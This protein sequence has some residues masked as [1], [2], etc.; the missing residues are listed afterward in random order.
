M[1][2][3][4]GKVGVVFKVQDKIVVKFLQA[5]QYKPEFAVSFSQVSNSFIANSSSE[6][7][8]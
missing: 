3:K 7:R 4:D 1:K 5:T 8:F 6:L 2:T